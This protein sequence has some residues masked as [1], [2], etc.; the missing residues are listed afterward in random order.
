MDHHHHHHAL[1][2][3]AI[4]GSPFLQILSLGLIWMSLHC[5]PMCGPILSGLNLKSYAE[6]FLYQTGRAQMYVLFGGLAGLVGASALNN[7]FLGWLPVGVLL[8]LIIIEVFPKLQSKI[9]YTPAWLSKR[10]ALQSKSST[11]KR[12]YSLGVLFSFLPCTLVV[13]ALSVAASSASALQG[14]L[15]M[16]LFVSMTL[17]P[18]LF[19]HI[20]IQKLF[21]FSPKYLSVLLLGLSFVWTVAHALAASGSIEHQHWNLRIGEH[22]YMIMFW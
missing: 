21:K 12:A 1:D 20:G 3:T 10:I 22:D 13:W 4:P 17:V 7:P 6:F 16:L 5:G 9:Q 15:V 11:H 14:A 19:V 18:L 8:V 2:A